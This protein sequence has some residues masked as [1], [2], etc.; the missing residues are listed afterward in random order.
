MRGQGSR[1][2]VC[3]PEREGVREREA[4]QYLDHW[5]SSLGWRAVGSSFCE[6]VAVLL[7]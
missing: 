6:M 3:P 5:D 4:G 2:Q 7:W 1:L